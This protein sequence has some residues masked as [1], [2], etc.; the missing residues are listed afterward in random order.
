M[1]KKTHNFHKEKINKAANKIISVNIVV[2]AI[3]LAIA[4]S[5]I[6]PLLINLCYKEPTKP[7][8]FTV[9]D[10]ADFLGYYGSVLG[11]LTTFIAVYI[12]INNEKKLRREER[13]LDARVYLTV[14]PDMT[15]YRFKEFEKFAEKIE[16]Y[17]SYGFPQWKH[18][19]NGRFSFDEEFDYITEFGKH[20]ISN[21]GMITERVGNCV[22]ETLYVEKPRILAILVENSSD[23]PVLNFSCEADVEY[24]KDGNIT[25]KYYGKS[26]LKVVNP[27][28]KLFF[29]LP[30]NYNGNNISIR[31]MKVNYLTT[32]GESIS[33][34]YE[35][36]GDNAREMY[37]IDGVESYLSERNENTS[38]M[39]FDIRKKR[40]ASL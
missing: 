33:Y 38:T 2:I 27:G 29:L 1:I 4:F 20:K 17:R 10:G 23:K 35:T 39:Y 28:M 31:K 3:C 22:K 36:I 34:C 40:E 11:G 26:V 7:F 37:I 14:N 21:S 19:E 6:G 5:I 12:T 25:P 16:A 15:F 18:I 8:L 24:I 32:A 30:V 13:K 9:W